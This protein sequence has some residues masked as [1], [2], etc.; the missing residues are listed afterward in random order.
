MEIREGDVILSKVVFTDLSEI[1]K[2]TCIGY[3]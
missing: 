3:K 2:K 1:K